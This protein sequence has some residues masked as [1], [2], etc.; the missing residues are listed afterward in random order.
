MAFCHRKRSDG[1]HTVI[2]GAVRTGQ[3]VESEYT[4]IAVIS[5]TDSSRL[6]VFL[7]IRIPCNS[8]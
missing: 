8:S 5:G 2:Y 6:S 7:I 1:C 3:C 4:R